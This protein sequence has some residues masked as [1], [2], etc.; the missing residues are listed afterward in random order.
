MKNRLDGGEA[1]LEAFRSLGVDFVISS[2]GSEWA[3]LWE[4]VARQKTSGSAGPCYIDAWHETLAVDVAIGYTL[5]TGRM[6]AVLLHAGAGLLQGTCGIHGALLA[7]V[8]LLVCSSEAITYGER[9][10]VDPGS[11]WYRNLS[12]VGGT[13]GLVGGIVKWT[14]QVGSV[15][16][17]YEMVKRAGELAQRTPRGPVYLNV[18]VEVLLEPWSPPS[19]KM[20]VAAPARRISPPD[21]I[22]R[23]V[24]LIAAAE[25]PIVL[26][27]SAGRSPEA[28]HALVAFAEAFGI[29]VIETQGTVCGNFPKKHPLYLGSR[30]E[31]FM[32]TTDLVLLVACRAP[33]Y[34]PSNK[35]VQARTVV[36]DETPQR[37]QM[38]H[39]VLFADLYLEGDIAATLRAAAERAPAKI[40]DARRRQRMDRHAAAHSKLR[41][42]IEA[43][44]AKAMTLDAIAPAALVKALRDLLSGEAIFVDET[45][46]H[47]RVVQQHLDWAGPKRYF[48][49][50]GGLGQGIGVALGI[51]MAAPDKPDALLLGDGTFLYNPIVQALGA[52][53]D[54]KLPI[55][56][57]IFNNKKYL[58]MKFNHLRAYPDGVAVTHDLFHGV[59]LDTQPPLHRFGE[60]FDMHCAEVSKLS[61]LEG[62]VRAAA[63]SV[64]EGRTAILNVML[65][66]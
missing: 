5:Y 22:E 13:H 45:I 58:S 9:P 31:P 36:I 15:E 29:P 17:L 40:D 24:D 43:A 48:Y 57:V 41:A 4:A 11:Q 65:T 6:Q 12:I 60:P 23:L 50:Q 3:P 33:W 64:A 21:E 42:D 7:E 14:N 16:I 51:K 62:A 27:E 54:S 30:V 38:V 35:P 28:F 63:A 53:R 44:E 39:Q 25:N 10:G 49:V 46:T 52:V 61:D 18:P 34:P 66:T 8:P 2:P 59:N 47:S 19:N 26:T 37:P 32:T 55:L 20:P 56:I 1:L